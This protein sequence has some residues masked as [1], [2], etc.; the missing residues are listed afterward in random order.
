MSQS[1][2]IPIPLQEL[3]ELTK[4]KKE[5]YDASFFVR[6]D[7]LDM[8]MTESSIQELKAPSGRP[9]KRIDALLHDAAA[10]ASHDGEFFISANVGAVVHLH[11]SQLIYPRR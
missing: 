8:G 10:Q 5:G 1:P 7:E 9:K 11:F 2:Y 3:R 4:L 6:Q